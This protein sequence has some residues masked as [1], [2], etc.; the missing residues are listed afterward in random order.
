MKLN[1]D[2]AAQVQLEFSGILESS[3]NLVSGPWSEVAPQPTSPWILSPTDNGM[4]FRTFMEM[5][6]PCS[7]PKTG[8]VTSYRTGD[9]GEYQ[10]GVVWPDPR[11]ADNGNTVIDN[12]T[13]L[14]W[15]KDPHGLSG[16][17][18]GMVWSSALNF[19][20]DLVYDG[21]DDW[22]LPN[23]REME[24]LVH[25]GKGE[26]GC[27]AYV[28]LLSDATPFSGT[29][30]FD[31]WSSTTSAR[32]SNSAWIL[33][34][35]LGSA[36]SGDPK[37]YSCYVWPVRGGS[38][39]E[40]VP[41]PLPKTGQTYCCLT[42]DDGDLEKGQDWPEPRFEDNLD[43]T[44]ADNL[45]GLEWIKAPHDLNGNSAGM[46]WEDAI[47]L[48]NDV[49]FA[50]HSDWR[51]PSRRELMSLADAGRYSPALPSGHPFTGILNDEYWSSTSVASYTSTAWRVS[52]YSGSVY[53]FF[54][55]S[56]YYAWPVRDQQ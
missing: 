22:R 40:A 9:D 55:S 5:S 18:E 36:Y 16:N 53:R 14:Q 44:I 41:A 37:T 30:W 17:A 2:G 26:W 49:E 34:M 54:K 28:W 35:Y 21:H 1:S 33:S 56:L 42:G 51:L 19:C 11:F 24:S 12:L 38:D 6:F 27:F 20:N 43:G 52:M 10:S 47:D 29:I 48:C 31:Y 7:V 3:T 25:S 39:G 15:I 32:C 13:G 8:Q 4:F 50:G 23:I 46:A 45:T